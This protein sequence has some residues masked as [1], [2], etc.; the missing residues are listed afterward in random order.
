[1]LHV[2]SSTSVIDNR[3]AVPG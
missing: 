3:S 1:V 2:A